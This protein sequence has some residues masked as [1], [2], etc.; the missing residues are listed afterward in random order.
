MFKDHKNHIYFVRKDLQKPIIE[1]NPSLNNN[2]FQNI[3]KSKVNV[4]DDF[5]FL[6]GVAVGEMFWVLSKDFSSKY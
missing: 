1:Y 5:T 6:H 2:G 3:P 4:E